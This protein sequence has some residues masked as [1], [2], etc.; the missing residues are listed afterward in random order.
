MVS[1][2]PKIP[3]VRIYPEEILANVPLIF[4]DK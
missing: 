2:L 1:F 3:L 4:R